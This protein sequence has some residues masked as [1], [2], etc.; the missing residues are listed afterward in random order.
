MAKVTAVKALNNFFN[1]DKATKVPLAQFASEIRSL[2]DEEKLE[3][4]TLAAAAN[5]DTLS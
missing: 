1:S 5:G 3:L 2:S 4:A